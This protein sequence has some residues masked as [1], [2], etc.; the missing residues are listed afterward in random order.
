M[1]AMRLAAWLATCVAVLATVVVGAGADAFDLVDSVL[2]L[3]LVGGGLLILRR[4][5]GHGTGRLFCALGAWLAVTELADSLSVRDDFSAREYAEWV[6][7]WSWLG[8][9]MFGALILLTFPDG[10]LPGRRWRS[11]RVALLAGAALT[12]V[13]YGLG[14][15]EQAENFSAGVNPLAG[16]AL[17]T[18]LLFDVGMSLVLL[19]TAA[20]AG[21]L[22]VRWR[23]AAGVERQQ[24]KWFVLAAGFL[25][26]VSPFAVVFC[27]RIQAIVDRRFFRRRYDAERTLSAFGARVRDEVDLE[28]LSRELRGVVA[29]TMQPA[30]VS[31]WLRS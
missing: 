10:R 2:T 1:S 4:Q 29:D 25:G 6:T 13:G 21:A 22:V 7:S 9:I 24:L 16:D 17:P 3:V 23:R 28:A 19:A 5:P 31:L 18:A 8:E 30:R 20:G 27:A 15:D 12:A 14:T 26:I 11:V